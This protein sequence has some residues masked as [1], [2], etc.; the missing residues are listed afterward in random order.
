MKFYCR[1]VLEGYG[2]RLSRSKTKYMEYKFIIRLST[3]SLKVKV[4][5]LTIPQVTQFKYVGSIVQSD[6]YRYIEGR[7]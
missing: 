7:C 1:Q 5:D 3:P 4:G 6:K 2:F